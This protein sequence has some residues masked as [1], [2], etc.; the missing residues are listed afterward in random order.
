MRQFNNWRP[1]TRHAP[2]WSSC[3]FSAVSHTQRL[4]R[5]SGLRDESLIVTGR[6]LA[7]GC[8]SGFSLNNRPTAFLLEKF[9]VQ[10]GLERGIA[11]RRTTGMSNVI[12]DPKR[13]FLD[14]LER[15]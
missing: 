8:M 11:Y 9:P 10:P 6:T 5:H 12:P 4:R 1:R 2:N 13:I 15:K 3:G 7:P 14:A